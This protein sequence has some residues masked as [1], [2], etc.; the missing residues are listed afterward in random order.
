MDERTKELACI[1]ASVA[2]HCQPCF[3]Y[4]LKK[5]RELRITEEDVSKVIELAINISKKGDSSMDEFAKNEL[6]KD[7]DSRGKT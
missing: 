7:K 4:H 6:D 3:T 2:G 1:A 5:S